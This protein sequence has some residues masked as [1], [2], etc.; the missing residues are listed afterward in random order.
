MQKKKK[1]KI[2]LSICFLYVFYEHLN[3]TKYKNMPSRYARQ[4]T[5]YKVGL[6]MVIRCLHSCTILYRGAK[7]ERNERQTN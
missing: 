2:K 7:D 6:P 4:L 1:L 5:C 3:S